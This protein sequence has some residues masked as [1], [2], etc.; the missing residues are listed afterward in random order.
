MRKILKTAFSALIILSCNSYSKSQM[1]TEKDFTKTYFDSLKIKFPNAKFSIVDDSII[2]SIFKE[3]TIKISVDNAYKEYQL[4]RDSL[5]EI[6][7]RYLVVTSELF[8]PKDKIDITRIVPIIK[9]VEFL[10]DIKNEAK[11]IG[12]TK[13]VEGVYEQYNDQLIIAYAEDTKNSIRYLTHDDLKDLPINP[14]SLRTIAVKNVDRLLTSIQKKGNNGVYMLVAGGD[15]EASIILLNGI[16]NKE[17]FAVN[18]D[19]VIT[20]PNRDML[21]IT[22]S[23]DKEGI[24]KITDL[25]TKTYQTGNYPISPYLYK[26]NGNKFEKFK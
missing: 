26:W 23:T 1:L 9:P 17:N 3:N 24:Q 8:N 25:A 15:Y 21:L 5:Q 20:I 16:L 18:G 10:N 4:Q 14:D 19:L 13:D 22:G 6:L 2:E 7:S 11:G 12:A